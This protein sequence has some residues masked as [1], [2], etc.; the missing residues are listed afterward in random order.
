MEDILCHKLGEGD[1]VRSLHEPNKSARVGEGA[2][3]NKNIP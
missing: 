2:R 3:S 1:R